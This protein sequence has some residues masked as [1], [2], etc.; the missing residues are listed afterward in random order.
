MAV[1]QSELVN[2]GLAAISGSQHDGYSE[3][4]KIALGVGIG[5]GLSIGIPGAAFAIIQIGAWLGM[6]DLRFGKRSKPST[7]ATVP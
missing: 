5:V 3:D 7:V 1:N 4:Q 6:W 2:Q